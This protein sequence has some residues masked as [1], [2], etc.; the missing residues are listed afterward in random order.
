MPAPA[1]DHPWP[2]DQAESAA[3]LPFAERGIEATGERFFSSL[4]PIGQAMATYLVCENEDGIVLVDQHAAD[5]RIV[6]SRLK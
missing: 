3:A 5:E 6:F 4:V 1:L 2:S